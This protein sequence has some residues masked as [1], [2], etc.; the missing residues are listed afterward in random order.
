MKHSKP[1]PQSKTYQGFWKPK[2]WRIKLPKISKKVE[3]D[4][5]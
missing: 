5:A 1:K 4:N 3:L 2:D